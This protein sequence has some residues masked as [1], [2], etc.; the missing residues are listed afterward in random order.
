MTIRIW[1]SFACNNSS[2]FRLVGRFASA[3]DAA[4]AELELRTFLADP[5]PMLELVTVPGSTPDLALAAKYGLLLD[6]QEWG[7]NPPYPSEDLLELGTTEEVLVAYHPYC[8]G[9]PRSLPEYLQLRG[10][11]EVEKQRTGQ[12]TVSLLFP[13]TPALDAELDELFPRI[14]AWDGR[15]P[16]VM[17][18][19]K[20]LGRATYFR[21]AATIGLYAR[22]EPNDLAACRRW[23]AERGVAPVIR[24]CEDADEQRYAAIAAARCASCSG[25]LEYLDPR[26]HDIETPQLLCRPCGGFFDLAAFAPSETL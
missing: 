1:Q 15:G 19:G 11:R 16:L 18:W 21:D 14:D 12:P 6:I 2:S 17:P 26:L 4:A 7:G 23:F 20:S 10:A 9:F 5:D 13:R 24:L 22:I 25:P 3:E 8:L